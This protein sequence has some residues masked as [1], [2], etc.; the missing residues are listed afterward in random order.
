MSR[1]RQDQRPA[2]VAI[3]V[4]VLAA[5][6]TWGGGSALLAAG[7]PLA[8]PLLFATAPVVTAIGVLAFGVL[9]SHAP[10]VAATYLATR[11]F[12]ATALAL[13]RHDLVPGWLGF[14]GAGGY[15]LLAIGMLGDMAG[16]GVGMVLLVPG[17]LFELGFATYLIVRGFRAP[18][19]LV[20]RPA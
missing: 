10:L 14:W 7:S 17:G 20:A 18:V 11:G 2:S 13:A 3:G 19:R 15:A 9:H 16:L 5:F 8:L 6:A 1:H 4:F 12:E